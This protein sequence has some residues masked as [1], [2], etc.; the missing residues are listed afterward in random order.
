MTS[1]LR[2]LAVCA[3]AWLSLGA[4]G[5]AA[6]ARPFLVHPPIPSDRFAA[7]GN[8]AGH[9]YV[10]GSLFDAEALG[11]KEGLV[12]YPVTNGVPASTPD[13]VF[14]KTVAG[15]VTVDSAGNVYSTAKCFTIDEF[16]PNSTSVMN[17]IKVP[18]YCGDG[19]YNIGE[20]TSLAVDKAGYL[21]VSIVVQ[22]VSCGDQRERIFHPAASGPLAACVTANSKCT[23]VYA[24]GA[25][26]KATP[27]ALITAAAYTNGMALNKAGD[28]FLEQATTGDYTATSVEV[29]GTPETNPTLLRTLSGSSFTGTTGLA[30]DAAGLLYVNDTVESG[31]EPTS[32][33]I[34]V[35]HANASGT[36]TP[37]RTFSNS[38]AQ[39]FW[40]GIGVDN[41]YLYTGTGGKLL[42]KTS[43]MI[44]TYMKNSNGSV[45]PVASVPITTTPDDPTYVA[46]GP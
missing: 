39:V 5:S 6:I 23:I 8:P 2:C 1:F 7:Q 15:A 24:P 31:S 21:Y 27:V 13:L 11:T 41:K 3:V 37:L 19:I 29:Y 18:I 9:L 45:T 25:T 14:P 42:K 36:V 30:I 17:S 32:S 16:A 38:P 12:R 28:L 44:E 43:R 4:V 20:V 46:V 22:C 10:S 34:S 26:G 40:Y 33:S 35:F